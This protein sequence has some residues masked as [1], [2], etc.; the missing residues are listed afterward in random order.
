MMQK[1]IKGVTPDLTVCQ[2]VIFN[3]SLGSV[4]I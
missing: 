3:N 4:Y 2:E 1:A